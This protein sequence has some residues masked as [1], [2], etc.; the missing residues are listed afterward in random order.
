[1]IRWTLRIAAVLAVGWIICVASPFVA[2]HDLGRAVQ[3]QDLEAIRDRVNFRAVRLSLLRQIAHAYVDESAGGA[4]GR[5]ERQL[6]VEAAIAVA[7]PVLEQLLTPEALVTLLGQ[8]RLEIQ[9]ASQDRSPPRPVQIPTGAPAVAGA[10]RV[11]SLGSAFRLFADAELRGFRTIVIA[12]PARFPPEHRFR[13][14]LRLVRWTWRLVS[15]EL[16]EEVLRRLVEALPKA[17]TRRG[18]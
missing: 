8:G 3:E 10:L 5:G 4:L 2:L 6:A 1:M 13:L 7:D 16:S 15:L 18:S 11:R 17:P 14:R 9:V 12:L